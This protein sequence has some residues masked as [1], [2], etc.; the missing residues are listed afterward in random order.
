[1]KVDRAFDQNDMS[2][3]AHRHKLFEWLCT[4]G[5]G[6][7]WAEIGVADGGH[8][9]MMLE[10]SDCERLYLV[11][12]WDPAVATYNED[13]KNWYTKCH[14]LMREY[15]D[16]CFLIQGDSAKSAEL[17]GDD[18]LDFVFIDADHRYHGI[19]GDLEA[20]WP[21]V[22]SGGVMSGH[23]YVDWESYGVIRAVDEFV[24]MHGLKLFLLPVDPHDNPVWA[25]VKP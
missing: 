1:M 25:F 8:A 12:L 13:A 20:W 4:T 18:Y 23:D 11:D 2:V 17:F 21:K 14:Q 10:N 15:P 6:G 19:S 22:R 5:R 3:I 16:R 24:A 9:R 7:N